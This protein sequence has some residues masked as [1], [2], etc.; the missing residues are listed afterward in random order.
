ME[1]P[2][3][4]PLTLVL[5]V[6]PHMFAVYHYLCFHIYSY[7]LGNETHYVLLASNQMPRHNNNKKYWRLPLIL[8]AKASNVYNDA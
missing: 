6:F 4:Q 5:A 7:I 3:S 8:I 1:H 2:L